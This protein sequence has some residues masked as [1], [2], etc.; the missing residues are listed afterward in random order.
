M[1]KCIHCN[2]RQ[3]YDVCAA[4]STTELGYDFEDVK[5][6]RA[7]FYGVLPEE[8]PKKQCPIKKLIKKITVESIIVDTFV[9]IFVIIWIFV[10]KEF[11]N[12]LQMI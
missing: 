3:P 7:T 10:L 2:C 12:I 9:V 4:C 1:K 11:I 8:K 6:M 5:K